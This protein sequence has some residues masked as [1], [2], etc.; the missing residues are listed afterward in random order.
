MGMPI[1]TPGTGTRDQAI[2]DLIQSVAL[3]ETALA[4]IMNAE[5]EKMQAIIEMPD[6][7]TEQLME[8]NDSV[9]RMLN[10]VARLE[11]LFQTKLELFP[12]DMPVTP[13]PGLTAPEQLSNIDV[14]SVTIAVPLDGLTAEA[15]A[16]QLAIDAAQ[17][18]VA[19]GYTVTFDVVSYSSGTMVQPAFTRAVSVAYWLLTG[20]FRVTKD[21]NPLDTALGELVTILVYTTYVPT[22]A[23]DEWAK[24]DVS[25]VSIAVP[26][27]SVQ[28][29]DAAVASAIAAAVAQVSPAYEVSF[30]RDSYDP[31]NG[32]LYGK[33]TVTNPNDPTDTMSD[34]AS[35]TITVTSTYVPSTATDE[36]AKIDV[37]T[38]SINVP[39]DDSGARDAAVAQAI[40]AATAQVSP[41]Y[42]VSFIPVSQDVVNGT[43]TGRFNVTNI[44]DLSDTATDTDPRTIAV[45][46][47]DPG[48]PTTYSNA[49]AQFLSGSVAGIDLGG[50]SGLGGVT[51]TYENGVTPGTEVTNTSQPNFD[52]L[53][54]LFEVGGVPLNLG[55]LLQIGLVNQYAQASIDGASRAYAGAVSD[56]GIISAD[57]TDGYPANAKLD[58]MKLI[59][60]QVTDLLSAANIT[61]GAITGEAGLDLST[62]PDTVVQNYNIAGAGFEIVSPVIGGLTT[63]LDTAID[64]ISST[65]NTLQTTLSNTINDTIL[66]NLAAILSVVPGMTLDSNSITATINIDPDVALAPILSE[67]IV[68]PGNLEDPNALPEGSVILDLS[69]GSLVVD[70]A[71]FWGGTLNNLDPNTVLFGTE[72]VSMLEDGK[73]E[74]LVYVTN[75][76]SSTLKNLLDT[77]TVV[78]GGDFAFS[79]PLLG[80]A[81]LAFNFTGSLADLLDGTAT[82]EIVPSGLLGSVPVS[83][84]TPIIEAIQLTLSTVIE[85]LVFGDDT[86]IVNIAWETMNNMVNA[87]LD[88]V[89]P[90]FQILAGVISINVNVQS[91]T[92]D[93]VTE[94]PVQLSLLG[95]GLA[96]L[97]LGKAVAG[98]NAYVAPV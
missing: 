56:S 71:K 40:A 25:S 26:L 89:E 9:N 5:G 98:P 47:T 77:A 17:A 19:P 37:T 45:T 88:A 83:L 80:P 35:R 48:T 92:A 33:Y 13:E 16:V 85:P 96:E 20:R 1:I 30:V 49:T 65:I 22:T 73:T 28:A 82:I 93:T 95:T 55:E 4:H 52:S 41:E 23:A 3:Q 32:I 90:V 81:G 38:V 75:L 68:L 39:L 50:L 46:Y 36:L 57:G 66:D 84:L 31:V 70:L 62:E 78:I 53:N 21:D 24:I 34:T 91:A 64:T 59:P 44:N 42:A 29:S 27:D 43:L 74:L 7:T 94:I 79:V 8:L 61:I 58:L 11:M 15:D 67:P 72:I 60:G 63:T 2:T 10:S 51:A 86:S 18:Q 12:V 69:A 54:Q 14:G 6:V 76:L 97:S 87:A